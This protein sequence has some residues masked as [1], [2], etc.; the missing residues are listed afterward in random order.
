MLS[1]SVIILSSVILVWATHSTTQ[2]PQHN[3]LPI[4][5]GVIF[6]IG[7]AKGFYSPA[8]SSLNP[9]LIPK[10][11]FANATTWASSFWQAGAILGQV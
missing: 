1:L 3:L 6:L 7:L 5:Y 10:E 4:I 2:L 9:F 8:S 11:V